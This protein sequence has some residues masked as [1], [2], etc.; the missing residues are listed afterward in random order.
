MAQATCTSISVSFPGAK[1]AST[2]GTETY[3]SVPPTPY[4]I[5]FIPVDVS[6]SPAG[7]AWWFEPQCRYVADICPSPREDSQEIVDEIN[8][9]S[10]DNF[11]SLNQCVAFGVLIDY[12]QMPCASSIAPSRVSMPSQ[13][14][15]GTVTVTSNNLTCPWVVGAPSDTWLTLGQIIPSNPG[16][17]NGSVAFSVPATTIARTATVNIAGQVLTVTQSSG[18]ITSI[19]R[20][21]YGSPLIDSV[22][23]TW[24]PRGGSYTA[25][26]RGIGLANVTGFAASDSRVSG[27][28]LSKT[29]TDV[30]VQISSTAVDQG[31]TANARIPA[32]SFALQTSSE[33]ISSGP[34]TFDIV[35]GPAPQVSNFTV[36]N[37][38]KWIPAGISTTITYEADILDAG[39]VRGVYITGCGPCVGTFGPGTGTQFTGHSTFQAVVT[40]PNDFSHTQ[41][42]FQ[43]GAWDGSGQGGWIGNS[44]PLSP[45]TVTVPVVQMQL[46]DPVPALVD[47]AT[48]TSDSTLLATQGSIVNGAAADGVTQLVIRIAGAPPNETFALNLAQ[49]GGLAEIGR[50]AF[51][52]TISSFQVD[53]SGEGFFLY[54]APLDFARPGGIDNLIPSRIVELNFGSSD[55]P[56][57]VGDTSIVIVR[58]PV[59]LVHGNWSNSVKDWQFFQF[60]NPGAVPDLFTVDY[61]GVLAQGVIAASN[62]I[63]PQLQNVIQTYK[64][65]APTRNGTQVPVAAVQA[66]LV[67]YS[68]GGLVSR[69]LVTLPPFFNGSNYGSGYVHKLITLDTPHHGSELAAALTASNS[70]CHAALTAAAGPIQQ[71]VQDMVPGS[72]LLR[73]LASVRPGRHFPTSV[74]ISIAGN[75]QQFEANIAYSP[76]IVSELCPNLLPPGGYQS[77]FTNGTTNPTGASDLIVSQYS[78]LA[79]GLSVRGPNSVFPIPSMSFPGVIHDANPVLFPLGPDVRQIDLGPGVLLLNYVG[80][81][82]PFPSTEQVFRLL[83]TP[84]SKFGLIA[85]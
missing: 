24:F 14:G 78:Q 1:I 32:V 52:P 48:V 69:A 40:A 79:S 4:N 39:N 73:G 57:V 15:S 9:S 20:K 41:F 49:D 59:V 37:S 67:A 2:N 71:N 53:S 6:V 60:A 34:V 31:D 46:V 22:P 82:A 85:P 33:S 16:S 44:D 76:S 72:V 84:V 5:W 17:G 8:A 47:G 29:D 19:Q 26:I 68:L 13:G 56:G 81:P 61:S 23:V 62:Y 65:G 75:Q 77:L 25:V 42:P 63:L 50:N 30:T 7:C 51:Q 11:C 12:S 36:T 10:I 35:V 27:S 58:P 45:G 28:I 3:L 43:F 74:I 55:N 21:T 38:V 66:D 83:N 80:V 18:Q 64:S 70:V 54:Q